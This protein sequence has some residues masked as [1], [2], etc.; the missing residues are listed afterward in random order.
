MNEQ[1]RNDWLSMLEKTNIDKG[2]YDKVLSYI[3]M[4][5]VTENLYSHI[6]VK[7]LPLSFSIF[8]M[9]DLDKVDFT[10]YPMDVDNFFIESSEG[11]SDTD[12]INEISKFIN[13][14][15]NDGYRVRIYRIIQQIK[16]VENRTEVH[17][18]LN[19]YK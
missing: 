5:L 3:D 13:E 4:Y 1:Y 6:D 11:F 18:R 9:I 8:G 15:L 10:S 14:K 12:I 16:K 19:F 17:F 7:I 2:H